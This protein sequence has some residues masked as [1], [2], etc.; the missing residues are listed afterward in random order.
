MSLTTRIIIRIMCWSYFYC[1]CTEISFNKVISNNSHFSVWYK[2]MDQLFSNKF[3][4]PLIFWVNCNSD[5]TKHCLNSCS[6]NNNFFSWIILELVGKINNDT[7]LHS[8][9]VS[10]NFNMCC[11]YKSVNSTSMSEIAVFKAQDQLTNLFDL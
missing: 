8:L 9:F 5:I 1:S 6:S 10:R 4:I 2:W 3:L 11:F 7:E